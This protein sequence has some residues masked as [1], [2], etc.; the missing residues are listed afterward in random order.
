MIGK[1]L[2]HFH[3]L[4]QLGAG[5][6]GEVYLAEDTTLDRKVA[7]KF[8]PP[9][10][11]ADD[12]AVKRLIREAKAAATLDH[13]NICAIYEI[14]EED[15]RTFIV[16][17]YIEGEL[18]ST[19]LAH[20][21]LT[22]DESLA[23]ASQ[24]ADALVVAHARGIV[25][26]DI[27]PQNIMLTPRGQ[28]KLM[29]FGLAKRAP[30][31]SSDD[32]EGK[33]KSLLTTPGAIVGTVNYM[34]PEQVRGEDIDARSDIFSFG[35]V[36]YEMISGHHPFSQEN[37]AS[38][39]NAILSREPQPVA[40]FAIDISAEL[41]RI[42]RK[43]LAKDKEERYQTIRDIQIDL[44][45]LT[46]QASASDSGASVATAG[47][48]Y[49]ELARRTTL[50]KR[51][52][53]Y[54]GAAIILVAI[55]SVLYLGL[56][57]SSSAKVLTEKDTILI[58]DFDNTTGDTVFDR[59]LKQ[60]LAVQLEQSPFLNIFADQRV[61]AALGLMGRSPDERVTRDVAREICEREDLK[62]LLSGSIAPL[63]SH[64]VI[65]I[66]AVNAR[67]GDILARQQ[68]EA[69]SKEQVLAT[70]GNAATKLREKLG[71]SVASI[72]KFDTPMIQATTSSLEALR[73][74][75]LGIAQG[76]SGKFEEAISLF[77]RAVAL[78]PNFATAYGALAVAISN[79]GGSDAGLYSAKAFALRDRV[80]ERERLKIS[81]QYYYTATGELDNFL[82]ANELLRRTYP[83]DFSARNNLA[84][85]YMKIGEYEKAVEEA[86]E[87]VRLNP[88]SAVSYSNLGWALRNLGRYDEAKATIE[89]AHA[90]NLDY[91]MMQHNLCLIGLVQG[92]PTAIPKQ[93]DRTR[94]KPDERRFLV[95]KAESEVFFG[96]FRQSQETVRRAVESLHGENPSTAADVAATAAVWKA[97]VGLFPQA[98][99]DANGALALVRDGTPPLGA[100]FALAL[101]GDAARAQALAVELAK[102][103]PT[104]T[105]VNFMA[106]PL[107]RAV[108][109][110]GRGDTAQ[111]IQSLQ[112]TRLYELGIDDPF[113]AIYVRGQAYL[114][115]GSGAEAMAEFQ[116]IIDHRSIS[117]MDLL[118]PLAHLGLARA[119]ALAGDAAKS[120]AAYQKFFTWWKDADSDL[121]ILLEAK[122]EYEKLK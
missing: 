5:G 44:K 50:T 8:L 43:S 98:R 64:Y 117:P 22:L 79:S 103:E 48:G 114:R 25:H 120:R 36:L 72:Q 54:A 51:L 37:L 67:T 55:V 68:V 95:L 81:S 49:P 115:Q 71:E 66:E 87:S 20:R 121:P 6:M 31:P 10:T 60:A 84:L 105:D 11:A 57:T 42:I 21:P 28:A 83:R 107:I 14:G 15:G 91:V 113:E 46:K 23:I 122:K 12:Q 97:F 39:I 27:K 100:V 88:N 82:E 3:L 119:S 118:Y 32:R 92:D 17:Q 26:R 59:A 7:I 1:V 30:A 29:D 58:A 63:G 101:C 80:T 116:K 4:S 74:Y 99:A 104:D 73:A 112:K 56:F 52:L 65:A 94:G 34:S 40:R 70:L 75:S 90:R 38:T 33:T 78:D 16:M 69:G 62:A 9:S 89:R 19:R 2:G 35:V 109:E 24:V 13:P 53:R 111:A 45:T 77:K 47:P 61:R 93:L 102:R 110:T 41:E 76:M 18:L 96:R 106:L 108:V 86:G 85:S